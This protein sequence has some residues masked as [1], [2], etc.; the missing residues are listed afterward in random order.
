M[1]YQSL[2]KKQ[3]NYL[4]DQKFEESL[5]LFEKLVGMDPGNPKI[6]SGILRSLIQLNNLMMQKKC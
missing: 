1:K 3:T 6:I 5:K 2:L 4:E